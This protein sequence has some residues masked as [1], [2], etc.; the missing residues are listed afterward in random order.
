MFR[1]LFYETERGQVPVADF[2]DALDED[3]QVK[4][5]RQIKL[6]KEFGNM[7]R[8]PHSKMVGNGIYELRII[9][10]GNIARVFYFFRSG[11]MIIL[12]NKIIKKTQKLQSSARR[13][14]EQY[15]F[16]YVRR[17]GNGCFREI[18]KQ[19]I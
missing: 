8:E 17:T 5:L 19:E 7:L 4:V 1:I 16:D 6:L 3:L 13:L 14:A 10:S 18:Y 2:I 9:E 15:M 11:R 12:T